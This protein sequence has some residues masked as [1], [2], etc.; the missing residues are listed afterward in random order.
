MTAHVCGI[1]I[2]KTVFHLIGLRPEARFI[3]RQ[4]AREGKWESPRD[5]HLFLTT[6]TSPHQVCTQIR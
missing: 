1:D 2:G 6:T 4:L 5:F 3:V